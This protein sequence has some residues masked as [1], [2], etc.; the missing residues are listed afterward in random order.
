MEQIEIT[1]SEPITKPVDVVG[2]KIHAGN[3]F[4]TGI[5]KRE[6][7]FEDASPALK[8]AAKAFVVQALAEIYDKDPQAVETKL[9]EIVADIKASKAEPEV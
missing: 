1:D 6:L 8:Q 9:L 4:V 7:F 2:V 3:I 5:V